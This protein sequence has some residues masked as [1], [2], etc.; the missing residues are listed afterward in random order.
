MEMT[1]T[2]KIIDLSTNRT[3]ATIVQAVAH[4]ESIFAIEC[5]TLMMKNTAGMVEHKMVR[6]VRLPATI[7][8][9]PCHQAIPLGDH[10]GAIFIDPFLRAHFLF[11]PPHPRVCHLRLHP[12]L[13]PQLLLFIPSK[14]T[15]SL[16]IIAPFR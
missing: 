6:V 8:T 12:L 10:Q 7:A 16:P 4:G 11:H 3:T 1:I 13:H 5:T 15:H 14:T 2:G 9:G